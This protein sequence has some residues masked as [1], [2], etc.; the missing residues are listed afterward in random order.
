MACF[1]ALRQRFYKSSI[2]YLAFTPLE[3]I[4]VEECGVQPFKGLGFGRS[5]ANLHGMWAVANQVSTL[6]AHSKNKSSNY[7]CKVLHEL[8]TC[9][10]FPFDSQSSL[11]SKFYA[12]ISYLDFFLGNKENMMPIQSLSNLFPY[13]LLRTSRKLSRRGRA[14]PS[15]R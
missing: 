8:S 14:S 13:P 2:L 10:F 7:S 11:N 4:P 1:T 3:A 5:C 9:T 15:R 6:A 12:R